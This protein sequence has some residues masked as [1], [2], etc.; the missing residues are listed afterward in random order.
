MTELPDD[1][2]ATP[3]PGKLLAGPWTPTLDTPAALDAEDAIPVTVAVEL[4]GDGADPVPVDRPA[5]VG[6][7]LAPWERQAER[8]PVL[9]PWLLDPEARRAAVVWSAGAVLHPVAFH[10]VRAPLYVLRLAA[11]APRGALRLVKLAGRWVLDWES[12]GL[13]AGAAGGSVDTSPAYLALTRQ[14]DGR[15]KRRA[16]IAGSVLL[17]AGVGDTL[18]WYLEP[19]G[20]WGGTVAAILGLGLAGRRKDKPVVSSRVT[21]AGAPPRLT[22]DAIV[23][24]LGA[25]SIRNLSDRAAEQIDFIAPGIGRDGHGWRAE[26]D[27]PFGVTVS[28][29][30]DARSRV[31]SGLRRPL[32]AVWPEGRPEVHPGRLILFVGDHDLSTLPPIPWALERSGTVDLFAPGSIPWG[33]DPRGRPV[34]VGLFENNVLIGAIPGAGKTAALRPLVLAV[35]LDPL[36]ESWVFNLKG[37]RDLSGAELFAT[38]Y[39]SSMGPAGVQAALEGLRDLKKEILRR[40]EVMAGIPEALAPD[41]SVT[42]E[43]AARRELGLHPLVMTIDEAQN[44]FS[45]SKVGE[46]AGQLAEDCIKLGRAFGVI[47][48]LATQRPD[49]ES[50]PTGVSANVSIRFCLRVMGQVENDMVLGT[51]AYKNGIRATTLR[52]SDKGIGMLVGGGD[53]PTVVRTAYIQIPESKKIGARA[54]AMRIAA[55]TL[56]GYAAGQWAYTEDTGPDYSLIADLLQVMAEPKAHSATLCGRLYAHWP[57]RY[58]ATGPDGERMPWAAETL[59]AALKP[60]GVT[61]KQVWAKSPGVDTGTNRN[62]VERAD[63][64]AAAKNS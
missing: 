41:G 4:D 63:L 23:R 42:R 21:G 12:H 43:L 5:L 54:R 33:T 58:A 40:T 64:V 7:A 55:G 15:L 53:E 19:A 39:V 10:A 59:A 31:A 57:E 20:F 25:A 22:S 26:L 62:G 29:V 49:K 1:D 27:L 46:E 13:I 2:M 61:T 34:K 6:E 56:T 51:S 48:M 17:V 38:R 8:R 47:L 45:D 50:V 11:N 18:L 28:D 52:P 16:S 44:L 60:F 14:R 30:L 36:S 9:A 32:G 3:A 24:A 35:G 37:N